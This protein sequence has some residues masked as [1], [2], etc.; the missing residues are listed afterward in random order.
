[1]R[2]FTIKII[3]IQRKVMTQF[4]TKYAKVEVLLT[5]WDK[6]YGQMQRQA[7]MKHDK[8]ATKLLG[9]IARVPMEIKIK[10]LTFFIK[11]CRELHKVAFF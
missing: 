1:M 8:A 2:D 3:Y 10:L 4:K 5:Y 7:S 9:R 6:L 11:K